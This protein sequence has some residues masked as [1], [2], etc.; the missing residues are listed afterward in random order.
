MRGLLKL[1]IIL[2]NSYP[3]RF[4]DKQI[5]FFLET[6]INEKSIRINT[7]NN[8]VRH[9]KLPHIGHISTDVKRKINRFCKFYC[10]ILSIKTVLTPF[11]VADMFNVI[12]AIPNPLKFFVLYK[13]VCP[14]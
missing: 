11:K 13:F 3:L 6:K 2:K 12:D 8:I 5:K 1:R 4:V 10:K 14:D 7:T 9:Y